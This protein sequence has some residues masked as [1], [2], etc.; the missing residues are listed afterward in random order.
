MTPEE[1]KK[2]ENILTTMQKE[3]VWLPNNER[4]K[5]KDIAK[6]SFTNLNSIITEP[7]KSWLLKTATTKWIAS[8]WSS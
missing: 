1:L 3:I 4:I 2:I 6:K 7:N 8:I 5:V